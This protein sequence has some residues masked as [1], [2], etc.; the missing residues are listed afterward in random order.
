MCAFGH[1]LTISCLSNIIYTVRGVGVLRPSAPAKYSKIFCKKRI[2]AFEDRCGAAKAESRKPAPHRV[3]ARSGK[4]GARPGAV[5]RSQSE[6]RAHSLLCPRMAILGLK[7]MKDARFCHS[8]QSLSPRTFKL[9]CA[10][11]HIPHVDVVF[12]L[13]IANR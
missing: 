1:Q 8:C 4:P 7:W 3:R 10:Q 6:K 5:I 13:D 11:L 2:R 9:T 12:V